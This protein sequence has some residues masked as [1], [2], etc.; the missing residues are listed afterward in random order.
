MWVL[1]ILGGVWVSGG[2]PGRPGSDDSAGEMRLKAG[3]NEGFIS[4]PF[5]HGWDEEWPAAGSLVETRHKVGEPRQSPARCGRP[6]TKPGAL[7]RPWGELVLL[8]KIMPKNLH[9]NSFQN[10]CTKAI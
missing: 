2:R 4:S 3:R 10:H 1:V 6:L 7:R 8:E 5:G 9:F